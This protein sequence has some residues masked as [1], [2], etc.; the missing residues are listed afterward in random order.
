MIGLAPPWTGAE[1]GWHSVV[2]AA[3]E[4]AASTTTARTPPTASSRAA[5]S[6]GARRRAVT[7]SPPRAADATGPPAWRRPGIRRTLRTVCPIARHGGPPYR[8][9]ATRAGHLSHTRE[10][11]DGGAAGAG[12]PPRP[13]LCGQSPEIGAYRRRSDK[14]WRTYDGTG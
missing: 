4:Q 6:A 2:L 9:S 13:R 10:A 3:P 14:V 11:G 1:C 7:C 8:G 5:P 12:H